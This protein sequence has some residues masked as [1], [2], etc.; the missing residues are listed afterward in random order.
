MDTSTILM[1][2]VTLALFVVPAIYIQRRQKSKLNIAKQPF[3]EAANRQGLQLGEHDFWNE[4][5][6]IGLDEANNRLYFWHKEDNDPQET[7]LDLGSVK[8]SVVENAHRDVNGN[9]IIDAVGLRI[10]FYGAK[11]TSVY[12]PFYV[13]K[14][15]MMLKGELQLAEKWNA[16]IQKRI[17]Q[18]PQA[19]K[20]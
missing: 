14:D 8:Q 7:I 16:I 17:V 12:L 19:V 1:V 5:Y 11:A 13:T 18:T 15:I 3:I 4:K 20:V 6:G 10:A 2:I 9:R